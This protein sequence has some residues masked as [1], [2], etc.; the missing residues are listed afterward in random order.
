MR[1]SVTV[2]SGTTDDVVITEDVSETSSR[3]CL[4]I[5]SLSRQTNP[6]KVIAAVK[7]PKK[8]TRLVSA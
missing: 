7:R 6:R 3:P 2:S 8:I 5:N 1:S 4:A